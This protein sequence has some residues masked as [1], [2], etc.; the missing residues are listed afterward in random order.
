MIRSPTYLNTQ[1]R[2]CHHPREC[3]ILPKQAFRSGRRLDHARCVRSHHLGPAPIAHGP[4]AARALC[5][6][7]TMSGRGEG[8]ACPLR[9]I[10][11][12]G[13]HIGGLRRGG[14]SPART[15]GARQDSCPG[16]RRGHSDSELGRFAVQSSYA[17]V[18]VIVQPLSKTVVQLLQREFFG[19]FRQTRQK[20][21]PD[22]TIESS[23]LSSA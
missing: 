8:G 18:I 4:G 23:M 14:F 10:Q 5:H 21:L 2:V 16:R 12:G 13:G 19:F 15:R 3:L 9:E 11:R 6:P 1:R 17:Q 7:V 22:R 20:P